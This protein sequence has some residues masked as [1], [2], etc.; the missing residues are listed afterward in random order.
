MIERSKL[1]H[2]DRQKLQ[3]KGFNLSRFNRY[4]ISLTNGSTSAIMIAENTDIKMLIQIDIFLYF[5]LYIFYLSADGVPTYFVL[6]SHI[7][8]VL[9][10][11]IY[12]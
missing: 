1:I 11:R 12:D 5:S 9:T 3:S 10:L 2:P 7:S 6:L 4:L 8:K